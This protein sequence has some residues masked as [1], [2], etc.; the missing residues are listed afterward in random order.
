[1]IKDRPNKRY[2]VNKIDKNFVYCVEF[3]KDTNE[4]KNKE[5]TAKSLRMS[6]NAILNN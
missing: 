4:T 1:M 6:D 5:Y 3:N 2:K